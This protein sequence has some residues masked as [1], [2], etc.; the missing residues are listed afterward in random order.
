MGAFTVRHGAAVYLDTC[1]SWAIV[2][3][4]NLAAQFTAAV[5]A[6]RIVV[7]SNWSAAEVASINN[8]QLRERA[9]AFLQ[10]IADC[11]SFLEID[12]DII[13]RS[14]PMPPADE[15]MTRALRIG[16][17]RMLAL[18]HER[19]GGIAETKRITDAHLA[20]NVAMLRRF[21]KARKQRRL[22]MRWT[23]G[24]GPHGVVYS[25]PPRL[26]IT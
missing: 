17:V 24:Q 21:V 14:G 10:R 23:T 5:R 9:G 26:L 18:L 2:R 22:P 12:P 19:A 20:A 1:A 7:M 3:D 6:R 16:W 15:A 4:A 13:D 8:D 25:G 11:V